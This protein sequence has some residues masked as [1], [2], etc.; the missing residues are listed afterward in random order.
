[1]K[2]PSVSII[3]PCRNEVEYIGPCLDSVLATTYPRDAIEILVVDGLSDDGTRE[4]LRELAARCPSLRVLDNPA[5]IVPT[6]L[7][8]GIRAAAGDIIIRMDA[9]ALYPPRYVTALVGALQRSGADN[10]GGRIVA[11]PAKRTATARAVAYALNHPLGVGNARFRL[12]SHGPAWVDTVPFGCFPRSVFDRVGPFDEDLVRNQDDEFNQRVLRAGGRI[13]LLPDIEATYFPRASLSKL[14]RTYYQ[15]GLFKPLAARKIG[16]VATWR[17]LVPPTFVV[18]LVALGL[19]GAVS[20]RARAW[21]LAI[22]AVYFASVCG[23]ALRAVRRLGAR[24]A[25]VLAIAFPTIHIA[26]GVGFIHGLLRFARARRGAAGID[27]ATVPL[28][29]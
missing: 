16:R 10:V 29:R 20:P 27:P 22:T 3:I 28:S 23:V 6:A 17:Q 2:P 13:L 12:P 5:R 19:A 7:N 4:R 26:Y 8:L 9:H 18:T 15:Y 21:W 11:Y 1:M 14:A 24:A 25:A